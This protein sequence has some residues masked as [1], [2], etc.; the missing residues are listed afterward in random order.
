MLMKLTPGWNEAVDCVANSSNQNSENNKP[1]FSH[2]KRMITIT[3]DIIIIY[4]TNEC[5][6]S[7]LV[8]ITVITLTG[9]GDN[10]EN[11]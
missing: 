5:I 11:K 10:R 4:F 6:R 3:D 9:S 7:R 1:V 2:I 8:Q